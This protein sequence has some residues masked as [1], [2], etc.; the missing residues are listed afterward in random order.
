MKLIG[1]SIIL[2]T[3]ASMFHVYARTTAKYGGIAMRNH[4]VVHS[5]YIAVTVSLKSKEAW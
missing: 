2:R 5:C 1:V 3:L 4:Q